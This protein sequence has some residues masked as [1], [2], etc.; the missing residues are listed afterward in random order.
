M[1]GDV[2]DASVV[3]ATRNR[4]DLLQDLVRSLA[5][6]LPLPREL[7]IVDDASDIPIDAGFFPGGDQLRIRILRNDRCL[8]PGASRNRGVHASRGAVLLFTDDDC[9]VNPGWAGALVRPLA[10][11]SDLN[12]GGLGGRVLARDRDVVSRYFEFHRILEPRTHDAAHPRRI[13][14]LVTANCAVRRDVFMRA[15]GFDGRIP[16]AGG[17]DAA[18]SMRIVQRGY[19]FEHVPDAVVEHRFRPGLMDFARTFYRYGLGGRYVVD[20]Y[21]PR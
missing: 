17:E 12:L 6:C 1:P 20:R 8:G 5:V 2:L 4:L 7:V 9:V 3:V 11:P 10:D 19:H 14:Y 13:P 18:F 15:C 21:L 16:A